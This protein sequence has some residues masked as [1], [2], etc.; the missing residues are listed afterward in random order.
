MLKF[1]RPLKTM[2]KSLVTVNCQKNKRFTVSL[3]LSTRI[4]PH[5]KK[6]DLLNLPEEKDLLG[7]FFLLSRTGRNI[8]KEKR[9]RESE[10]WGESFFFLLIF[11]YKK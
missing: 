9:G 1:Q 5:F 3:V 2:P 4:F 6:K 8:V 11:I 10:N 7:L